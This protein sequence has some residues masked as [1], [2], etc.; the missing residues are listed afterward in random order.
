MSFALRCTSLKV[1]TLKY[2]ETLTQR[3]S[4]GC[5]KKLT[6]HHS[7]HSVK[8]LCGVYAACTQPSAFRIWSGAQ[9]TTKSVYTV[10][11]TNA[12]KLLFS[13]CQHRHTDV[14]NYQPQAVMRNP[15]ILNSDASHLNS[16]V[17]NQE[18]T[19]YAQTTSE[20]SSVRPADVCI[21]NPL[22]L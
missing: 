15:Q 7:N 22:R 11:Y 3:S 5:L 1:K 10:Q 6:L 8:G 9:H 20:H 14:S 13:Q 19:E 12:Q 21:P 18:D 16:P 2:L 4:A 17:L